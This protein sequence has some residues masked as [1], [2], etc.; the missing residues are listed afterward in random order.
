MTRQLP[1]ACIV[2]A[3]QMPLVDR[4]APLSHDRSV[5]PE[6]EHLK[7]IQA[8]IA[9]LAGNSFLIK[10]W[11]ITLVAGLSAFAKADGDRSFAWIA[12]GVVVV[13][14]MLDAFYLSLE[15]AYRA[16]Y[17]EA[18]AETAAAWSLSAA[19]LTAR[20]LARALL[21]LSVLPLHGAAAIGAV[22]VA[23]ST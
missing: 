4:M 21:S 9:R 6:P 23:L 7:L 16:L 5:A 18:V 14:A 13:F 15:R 3:W 12:F 2:A 17:S 1:A 10:G 20:G 11:T 22:A 19:P 8:I